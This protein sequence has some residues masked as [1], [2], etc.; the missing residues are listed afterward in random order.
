MTSG[1]KGFAYFLVSFGVLLFGIGVYNFFSTL[2]LVRHGVRT[3]GTIVDFE[4]F[5][6]ARDRGQA[7]NPVFRFTTANNEVITATSTFG[8]SHPSLTEGEGVPVI[9]D[10]LKPSH[11]EMD[12]TINLWGL[13]I[14]FPLFGLAFFA[15][16]YIPL[17]IASRHS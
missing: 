1:Q 10:P 3:T 6:S 13:A 16:G 8:T 15:M 7:Y 14:F 5:V 11:S 12:V 4:K 17:Y 2:N 9:Y